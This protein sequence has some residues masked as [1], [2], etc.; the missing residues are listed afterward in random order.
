MYDAAV[1]RP[2]TDSYGW[3]ADAQAPPLSDSPILLSCFP[4]AGL[5]ATVAAHYM[6]QALNLPRIGTFDSEDSLPL[7]IV[8]GGQVH[9]P[10]RVYGRGGLAIVLSEFPP[11]ATAAGPIATAILAVAARIHARLVLAVEGVVPHPPGEEGEED[12]KEAPKDLPEEAVWFVTSQLNSPW[13]EALKKAQAKSLG[14]GIIGGISGALLVRGQSG[15]MP[16]ASLLVSA[17]NTEGFPDHRAA[18]ALIETIDRL[19][20]EVKIDTAP[21]RT[22]AALIER[23]LRDAMKRHKATAP[24]TGETTTP[25]A[26]AQSLYQ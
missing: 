21:L 8:Q 17:K 14:D 9:P 16:V 12:P 15:T 22:Q 23:A 2:M 19:F 10:I 11:A 13:S 18:A 6:V 20:P 5:A 1:R 24:P 4:S 25:S 7:A 3:H 26:E